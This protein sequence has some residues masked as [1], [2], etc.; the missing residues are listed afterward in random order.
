[1]KGGGRM[2]ECAYFYHVGFPVKELGVWQSV[3]LQPTLSRTMG[4]NNT[5]Q[6]DDDLTSVTLK[7]PW[8]SG[9]L[10]TLTGSGRYPLATQT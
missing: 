8:G 4:F 2:Q 10:K 6:I 5:V 9:A 3:D 1:M 7:D